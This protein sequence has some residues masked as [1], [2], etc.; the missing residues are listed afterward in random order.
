MIKDSLSPVT[1]NSRNRLTFETGSL[2]FDAFLTP[3]SS[4]K[5]VDNSA[6]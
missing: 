4:T 2:L 5:I 3:G 6:D 1:W